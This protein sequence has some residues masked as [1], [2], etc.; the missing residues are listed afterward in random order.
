[1]STT[2]PILLADYTNVFLRY[3]DEYRLSRGEDRQVIVEQIIEE[4]APQGKGKSKQGSTKGLELVS[5][6]FHQ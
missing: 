2:T 5:Q 3:E 4:I 1:M 6:L